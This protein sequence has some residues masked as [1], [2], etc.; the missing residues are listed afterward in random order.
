LIS[1]GGQKKRGNDGETIRGR[2][3]IFAKRDRQCVGLLGKPRGSRGKHF[4]GEGS[5]ALWLTEKRRLYPGRNCKGRNLC[6]DKKKGRK[7]RKKKGA[8]AKSSKRE[9]HI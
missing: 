9:Q 4:D 5:R 7:Q 6:L 2:A 8:M 3:A 1:P